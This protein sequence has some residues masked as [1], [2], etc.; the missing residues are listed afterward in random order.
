MFHRRTSKNRWTTSFPRCSALSLC[1]PISFTKSDSS[2]KRRDFR[3]TRR[4]EKSHF[5]NASCRRAKDGYRKP[6]FAQF[7]AK[8]C[9]PHLLWK[10]SFA[11]P[12]SVPEQL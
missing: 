5:C 8:S 10:R 3:F 9:R 11:L 2:K 6:R 1:E 4:N 7:I 12:F